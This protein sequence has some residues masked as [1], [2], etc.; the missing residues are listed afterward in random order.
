MPY[1]IN[2]ASVTVGTG[3]HEMDT[4]TLLQPTIAISNLQGTGIV[5]VEQPSISAE[6]V[7]KFTVGNDS[8]KTPPVATSVIVSFKDDGGVRAGGQDTTTQTVQI[9]PVQPYTLSVTPVTAPYLRTPVSM[10]ISGGLNGHAMFYFYIW[11]D[12]SLSRDITKFN[13]LRSQS[14]LLQI[15]GPQ[16]DRIALESSLPVGDHTVFGLLFMN[17]IDWTILDTENPVPCPVASGSRYGIPCLVVDTVTITSSD[18]TVDEA[19]SI[20]DALSS[21]PMLDASTAF[22]SAAFAASQLSSAANSSESRD[23]LLDSVSQVLLLLL[24]LLFCQFGFLVPF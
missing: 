8:I 3:A 4:Q 20:V 12:S 14:S 23:S 17:D 16:R 11:L 2:H 19:V 18:A 10:T 6:G 5:W 1:E 7:L 22:A 24:L 9:V 13:E 21:S 15:A